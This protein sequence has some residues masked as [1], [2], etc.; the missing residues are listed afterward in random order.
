VA[1]LYPLDNAMVGLAIPIFFYRKGVSVGIIGILAASQTFTYCFSPILLNKIS[2]RINRRKS[3]ILGV[4]GVCCAQVIYFFSLEPIPFMISKIIEGFMAGFIWANL[5]SSISDNIAHDHN[6]YM[7]RY[8]FSW[9][10]GTLSGFLLGAVVLFYGYTLEFIF[11][12]AP[13]IM[14]LSVIIIVG[15]FQESTNGNLMEDN[16]NNEDS[17]EINGNIGDLTK[18]SIPVILP[19]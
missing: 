7:A 18:Y 4:V 2:D 9:N 19:L 3:V 8:N 14:I 15:F 13:V 12:L 6:K 5:Q 17:G 1:F 16:L 11:Y 10:L